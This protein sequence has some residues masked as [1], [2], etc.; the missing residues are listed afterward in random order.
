MHPY[1]VHHGPIPFAHR[2]GACESPENTLAAFS[3]AVSLG[4]RYLETD[5]HATRDG[6][7]MAFHDDDLSRTC[8][9]IIARAA[10]S[11]RAG[12]AL[13]ADHAVAYRRLLQAST[14]KAPLF[15]L[16]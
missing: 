10:P 16:V 5:V 12:G 9:V 11:V 13:R 7:L 15:A 14:G 3:H 6:V 1:L 4:Y 8:G 2:G